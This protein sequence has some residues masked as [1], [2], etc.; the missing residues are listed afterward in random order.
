MKWML[1]MGVCGPDFF[2]NNCGWDCI[3]P[4]PAGYDYEVAIQSDI[5]LGLKKLL[6]RVDTSLSKE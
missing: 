4:K 6:Q 1:E 3:V 2:K 5:K